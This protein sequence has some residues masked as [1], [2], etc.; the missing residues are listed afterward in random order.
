MTALT[1]MIQPTASKLKIFRDLEAGKETENNK[2][3]RQPS[4]D[5]EVHDAHYDG[6]GAE[7]ALVRRNHFFGRH[8]L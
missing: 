6:V 8:T 2:P 1:A 4:G 5:G 3:C 7:R